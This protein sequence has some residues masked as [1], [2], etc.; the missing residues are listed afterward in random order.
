MINKNF[1]NN[2]KNNTIIINLARYELIENLED[3]FR[4]ISKGKIDYF[5]IDIEMKE[6]V[7]QKSKIKKF[8]KKFPDNFSLHPHSAFYSKQSYILMRKNTA[9]LAFNIIKNKSITKN[10]I[11]V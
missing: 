4:Y 10:K 11:Y 9:N 7:K 8:L 3:I 2:L 6:I 1:L 5:A